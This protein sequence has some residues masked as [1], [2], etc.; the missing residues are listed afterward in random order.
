MRSVQKGAFQFGKT[1]AAELAR[2]GAKVAMGTQTM[3]Q[4]AEGYLSPAAD[5]PGRP[6]PMT[7]R[8]P[9]QAW[10]DVD[11]ED[12]EHESRAISAYANQPIGLIPGLRSAQR[13]LEYDLLTARD[14]LIAVQGEVLE[15]EGPSS[16]ATAVARHAPTIILR[17]IIGATRAIGTTLLGVGNQI[18]RENMRRVEDVSLLT[19]YHGKT[20]D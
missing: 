8:S 5:S 18:D 19:N 15:S 11:A 4:G 16:A 20:F 12:E 13:Y 6:S 2:L 7:G 10:H 17:P 14:A 9:D 3:L 1:T